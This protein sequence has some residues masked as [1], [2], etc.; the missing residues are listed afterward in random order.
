MKFLLVLGMFLVIAS[1]KDISTSRHLVGNCYQTKRGSFYAI[2]DH[3]VDRFE[4]E[5]LTVNE[6]LLKLNSGKQHSH[7]MQKMAGNHVLS[8]LVKEADC[9]IVQNKVEIENLKSRIRELEKR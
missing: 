3:S 4:N 6:Y 5:T 1:C 8:E 2:I 9:D 7:L